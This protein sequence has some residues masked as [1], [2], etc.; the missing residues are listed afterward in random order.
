MNVLRMAFRSLAFRLEQ[1][2]TSAIYET[3]REDDFLL[4]AEYVATLRQLGGRAGRSRR[5]P[6]SVVNTVAPPA[7]PTSAVA[8]AEREC[9]V[10]WG[11]RPARRVQAERP[12]TLVY[13]ATVKDAKQAAVFPS[14]VTK[15]MKVGHINIRSLV[16]KLDE[17]R[18]TVRQNELDVLSI[19]ETW[20]T[21][22]VSSNLLVAGFQTFREDRKVA[23]RGSGECAVVVS[24]LSSATASQR[25]G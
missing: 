24:P 17:A 19:S 2:S 15:Q 18:L 22:E 12:R 11:R 14:A 7:R 8:G 3:T 6:R 13:P 25:A 16:P 21:S 5:H 10:I 1:L 4:S 20:L 9:H 23:K